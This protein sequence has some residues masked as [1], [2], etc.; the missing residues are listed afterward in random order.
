MNQRPTARVTRATEESPA[1]EVTKP[2]VLSLLQDAGRFG[3]MHQGLGNGGPMDAEAFAYCNRLLNNSDSATALETT[4]GGLTLRAQGSTSICVTGAMNQLHINGQPRALWCVHRVESGDEIAL[5]FAQR[6]CRNYLGVA[7]GFAVAPQFGSTATLVREGIGG[8][9]GRALTAGDRLPYLSQPP[10]PRRCLEAPLQ[11]RYSTVLT[12]RVI[13]GYQH[14][15]F[16]R[17][18]KRR[19]FGGPYTVTADADR[20]GYRLDGQRLSLPQGQWLSEGICRGA[21][22]TP[23]DGQPIVLMADRQTIGGYPKLGAALAVD[24][25][26]LAQLQTGGTVVFTPIS[27]HT[28]R[29]A[30]LLHRQYVQQQRLTPVGEQELVTAL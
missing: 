6:G 4:I 9:N 15:L 25:S 12:V 11:P 23:G 2:G 7:G 21:I 30:L 19:F 20:M 5:G 29:K 13:P 28:A 16:T 10:P 1:L 17:D 27:A 8:L 26:K 14:R 24:T 3:Y 18:Q 22:Q